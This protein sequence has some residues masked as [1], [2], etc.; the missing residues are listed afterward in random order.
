MQLR[1][2][3]YFGEPTRNALC[4]ERID[5]E[6]HAMEYSLKLSTYITVFSVYNVVHISYLTV[7]ETVFNLVAES[8]ILVLYMTA[9]RNREMLFIS[10]TWY[11]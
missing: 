7:C 5:T 2:R 10:I 11:F 6:K 9:F 1:S 8:R 4:M 3:I